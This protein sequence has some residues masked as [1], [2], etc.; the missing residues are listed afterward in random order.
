MSLK[1]AEAE[2]RGE[3]HTQGTNTCLYLSTNIIFSQVAAKNT[4]A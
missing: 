3:F 2:G 1:Y 4:D